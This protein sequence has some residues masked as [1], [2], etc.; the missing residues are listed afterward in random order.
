MLGYLGHPVDAGGDDGPGQ[1]EGL[2]EDP[3][4]PFQ[5]RG[6]GEDVHDREHVWDIRPKPS[7]ATGVKA[8]IRC[9]FFQMRSEGP[10]AHDQELSV[11]DGLDDERGGLKKHVVSFLVDEPANRS[12]YGRLRIQAQL[13]L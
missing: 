13:L 7:E 6:E 12:H 11:R 3:W 5:Y 2:D 4:E 10:L 1:G 8:E 9:H